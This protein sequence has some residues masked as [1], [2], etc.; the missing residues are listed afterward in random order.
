MNCFFNT[1]PAPNTAWLGRIE[2][3]KMMERVPTKQWCPMVMG[4]QLCLLCCKDVE[5]DRI[6]VPYPPIDVNSPIV[7]V[8][9]QSIKCCL[10]IAE[11]LPMIRYG[12]LL[13]KSWKLDLSA[14]G[15]PVIQFFWLMVQFFPIWMSSRC[16]AT[17]K[18]PM[19][20]PSSIIRCSGYI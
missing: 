1:A 14:I 13:G 10:V 2:P 12:F 9:V 18:W 7:T 11:S 4:A 6:W 16:I 3:G 20:A 8:S 17:F 19:Y 15:K 5:C